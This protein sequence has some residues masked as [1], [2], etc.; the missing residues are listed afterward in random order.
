MIFTVIDDDYRVLQ[1]HG[2]LF[3]MFITESQYSGVRED[4]FEENLV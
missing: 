2:C 1:S 3:R 4:K